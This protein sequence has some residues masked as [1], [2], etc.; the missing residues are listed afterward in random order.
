MM[1]VR[2]RGWARS[3]IIPVLAL[4]ATAARAEQTYAVRGPTGAAIWAPLFN[5]GTEA[6]I[7]AFT[8]SA[9]TV[10]DK[11]EPGPRVVF[12]VTQWSL[13]NGNPVRRQWFGDAALKPEWLPI[14]TDLSVG[15]LDAEV[16]GIL[17]EQQFDGS[18]LK[19]EVPGRI[20]IRWDGAGALANNTTQLSYQSPPYTAILQ[21]I[22]MGRQANATATVTVEALGPPIT[23][24]GIGSLTAV[25]EGLV[26]VKTP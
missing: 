26:S 24:V 6:I 8:Q 7:F 3:L 2:K 14:Q 10:G 22:G 5:G 15:Q 4:A 20:Q 21:T 17:E 1:S 12:S 23:L 11:P 16:V 18:I 9:P 13:V 19:R 25:T